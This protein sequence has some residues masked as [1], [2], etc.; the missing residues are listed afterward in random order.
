M[1]TS[2]PFRPIVHS[3]LILSL[4]AE[5]TKSYSG[6]GLDWYDL[7]SN[8]NNGTLENGPTFD[9]DG[10]ASFI[11]D[12][13]NDYVDTNFVPTIGTGDITYEVWF[14]TDTAQ[15][16]A[17]ATI[18]S[19]SAI[20]VTLV[21]CDGPT[22]VTGYPS[23]GS[24][25]MIYSYDGVLDRG[26]ASNETWIDNTWHC[27][28]SIHT[29]TSDTL[30]VDG[31]LRDS[32]T[33]SPLNI[34]NSTR[35][36]L[37]A[38]GNGSSPYPGW[39]FNGSISNTKVYN[40][41]LTP[42]EV[43]QNYNALKHRFDN[44]PTI[45]PI[46]TTGLI[47]NLDAGNPTSYPG[48]GTNWN[49]LST[50][51]NDGTLINLPTFDSNNGGSLVFDGVNDYGR[52]PYNSDFNLSSTNYTLEGWFNLNAFQLPGQSLIS[53]DTYGSNFDWS[54]LILDSTTLRFYSNGTATN[55][56]ATVPTM[57]TGQWY[58]YV[59]TSI[60]GVI[61]IYLDGVLYQTGAMPTSNSSQFYVTLGC[62]GWNSPA[63]FTNGKIS[64]LRVYRIGLTGTEVL[65]NYNA[66]KNRY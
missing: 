31:F 17:I 45:I 26:A 57:N 58:H 15:T 24:N 63:F 22:G 55:V 8:G 9:F 43:L 32:V 40:R 1:A 16:G 23:V 39:Y 47:L 28:V 27:V 36:L 50:Y 41:S 25:L 48:S 34:N 65:Q 54:L 33:T 7:T 64:I 30:Y 11:F 53:K 37:G 51:N 12:G 59:V 18:R 19:S 4:D 10:V 60:S 61:R 56:T 3:G 52:I 62:V 2:Y 20:Q 66:I 44:L 29:S 6:S 5:N 38:L 42:K 14:K 13:V 35:L 49:D 46:I 21:M